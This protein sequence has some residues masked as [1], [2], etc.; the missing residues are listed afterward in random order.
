MDAKASRDWFAPF[1]HLDDPRPGHNVMHRLDDMLAIAI[2]A[3]LCG[4]E[5]WTEVEQFANAKFKWLKT[6]LHL[7]HGVPSHDTF[8]RLFAALDPGQLERCFV[9]WTGR[10]HEHSGGQLVAID[11]KTLRRSFDRTHKQAAIHMVSVF[12]QSNHLVLGQLATAAKSNEITA[13]P[14]LVKLLDLRGATVTVDAMHCQKKTATAI[15]DARADYIMQAKANQRGVYDDVKL[16]FDEAIEH[17]WVHTG[18]RLAQT[19]EKGHGRIETRRCWSTWEVGWLQKRIK[20]PGLKSIVCIEAVR[21]IDGKTSTQRRYYLSSRDGRDAAA[22]LG[23][24]RGHWG[25]ENRLHWALD[26]SLGEDACR[27]RQGHAAENF[28]RVRR[29]ALNLN[30]G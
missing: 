12:S 1:R 5:G 30:Q 4:A 16:F 27:V 22:M 13:L 19:V 17:G 25:I 29:L 9:D 24:I 20:W 14:Q 23:A 8:G 26:V 21:E 11:G 3:V 15:L 2:L 7:P 28:S 10:L 18:H 6:F